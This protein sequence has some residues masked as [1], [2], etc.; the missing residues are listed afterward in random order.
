MK[1]PSSLPGTLECKVTDSTLVYKSLVP[2]SQGRL[3]APRSP[4]ST[5]PPL[6]H[7]NKD[8]S[9][10]TVPTL[11]CPHSCPAKEGQCGESLGCHEQEYP[12]KAQQGVD[13]G[14][15]LSGTSLI[16]PCFSQGKPCFILAANETLQV[17]VGL[18]GRRGG[19]L[20]V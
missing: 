20:A 12:I 1:A 14:R 4:R 19:A 10:P 6:E 9:R 8:S 3:P 2:L 11:Q 13:R 5:L 7:K 15:P 18:W 16:Q 17:L